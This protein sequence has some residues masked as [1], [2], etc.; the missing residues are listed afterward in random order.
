MTASAETNLDIFGSSS[1]FGYFDLASQTYSAFTGPN[2]P[3]DRFVQY[4]DGRFVMTLGKRTDGLGGIPY[5]IDL[6]TKTTAALNGNFGSGVRDVGLAADGQTVTLRLRLPADIHDGGYYSRE[7]LCS[8]V[9]GD[10][11]ITLTASYEATIPFAV[12][13]PAPPPSS[14]VDEPCPGTTHDCM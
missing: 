4:A 13:P 8:S 7:G 11:G 12:V 6:Q 9:T 10:C 5:L 3:L 14:P 2:A 1:A